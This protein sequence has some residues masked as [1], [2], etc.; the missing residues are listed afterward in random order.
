MYV[1]DTL[2]KEKKLH[3]QYGILSQT[4]FAVYRIYYVRVSVDIPFIM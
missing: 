2:M 4:V 1:A 3:R